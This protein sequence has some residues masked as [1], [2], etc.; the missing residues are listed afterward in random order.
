MGTVHLISYQVNLGG[1]FIG[2]SVAANRRVNTNAR[3]RKFE[4]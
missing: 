3:I 1:S 2:F 4:I